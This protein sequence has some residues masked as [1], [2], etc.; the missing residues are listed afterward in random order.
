MIDWGKEFPI[1]SVSRKTLKEA[2]LTNEQIVFFTDEKM[3][4]LASMIFFESM[5][6][7][8]DVHIVATGMLEES[9]GKAYCVTAITRTSLKE[10]GITDAEIATLTDEDIETIASKVSACIDSDEL[11]HHIMTSARNMLD[12]GNTAV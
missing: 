12:F 10:A 1:I 2:G 6:F 4:E 5:H 11:L 8:E 3:A 9:F 7:L